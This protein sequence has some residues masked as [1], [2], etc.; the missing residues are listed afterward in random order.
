MELLEQIRGFWDSDAA[1]YDRSASHA[2][3]TVLEQAVWSAAPRRLPP[4]APADVLDV[5]WA[6]GQARMEIE[7]LLGVT[8]GYLLTAG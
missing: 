5:E 1:F 2:P 7:R 3:R 4:P 8:P 6:T